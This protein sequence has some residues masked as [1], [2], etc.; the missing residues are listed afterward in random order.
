MSINTAIGDD[1]DVFYSNL[2][3]GKSAISNWSWVKN[4]DV[5]SKVG[6][7]LSQYDVRGKVASFKDRLPE[8]MHK[9]L[10]QLSKKALAC[11]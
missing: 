9:S 10:R 6:G 1:L 11:M 5:Y 3:A 7:D 4:R 2:L 8:R